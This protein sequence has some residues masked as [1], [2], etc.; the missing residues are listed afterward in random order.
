M[1]CKHKKLLERVVKQYQKIL[2]FSNKLIKP[3]VFSYFIEFRKL[4]NNIKNYLTI[5][6]Y[7]LNWS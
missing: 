1:V 5:I 3:N 4:Y 7:N 6:L 2:E